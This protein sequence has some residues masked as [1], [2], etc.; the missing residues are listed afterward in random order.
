MLIIP[1]NRLA[2]STVIPVV[3][4]LA[5]IPR[6]IRL[7]PELVE[8]DIEPLSLILGQSN[9]AVVERQRAVLDLFQDG[10]QNDDIPESSLNFK[11][12][13]SSEESI[14]VRNQILSIGKRLGACRRI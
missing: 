8:E 13:H 2:D 7:L 12:I 9:Q 10:L 6:H 5:S 14:R 4:S 1:L 11:Q 3:D